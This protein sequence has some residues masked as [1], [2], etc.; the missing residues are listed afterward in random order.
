MTSRWLALAVAVVLATLLNAVNPLG[1]SGR[2]VAQARWN[3]SQ[4]TP[5]QH[6]RKREAFGRART[7][8]VGRGLPFD[9][10]ALLS[11]H[12]REELREKLAN[13]PG[14]RLGVEHVG[15]I[16][17]VVIAD[18]V[19]L[20]ETS[21]IDGDTIVI[22]RKL[23]FSTRNTVIRTGPHAF[24]LFA[25]EPIEFE[26]DGTET[27]T[28]HVDARG[29]GRG[30][31]A[32]GTQWA[33]RR[34]VP[35]VRSV[36]RLARFGGGIEDGGAP[37]GHDAFAAPYGRQY[38]YRG[39]PGANGRAGSDGR[40]GDAGREGASG[41]AQ[42]CGEGG[43]GTAGEAGDT[44]FDGDE[45]GYGEDGGMGGWGGTV[46]LN[47]TVYSAT[48]ITVDV[49]GGMGGWGGN[50]GKGGNGGRGGSGG[51]GGDGSDCDGLATDGGN[52]G[53]GG[54]GGFGANGGNGGDGGPGGDGG[55]AYVY[56]AAWS[57]YVTCTTIADGGVGGGKGTGGGKGSSGTGGSGGTGGEGRNGGSAGATGVDGSRPGEYAQKGIDG[58]NGMNGWSGSG[59]CDIDP[60]WNWVPA[61]SPVEPTSR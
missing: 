57:P 2:A 5:E 52:G 39:Y 58:I 7:L 61:P 12:W 50:G 60:L 42:P 44:G 49:S 36:G 1:V 10:D 22:A 33:G 48:T 41:T 51:S 26:E 56:V 43:H 32:P 34:N 20:P 29:W 3:A 47:L 6:A 9:A 18:I 27:A 28:L 53:T 38:E 23:R 35:R 54:D 24:Y 37:G 14:I 4:E 16:E 13:L 17:G 21:Q 11:L 45:G 31:P 40:S 46:N 25:I 15:P 59:W 8:L 19:N 30:N 55:F